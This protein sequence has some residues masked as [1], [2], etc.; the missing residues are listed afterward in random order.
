MEGRSCAVE[1]V[2][3]ERCE[4]DEEGFESELS[5]V[6]TG[7][8]RAGRVRRARDLLGASV[9]ASSC[10]GVVLGDCSRD[11]TELGKAS[12]SGADSLRGVGPDAGSGPSVVLLGL[13]D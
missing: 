4:V 1:V 12:K 6:A 11:A 9:L 10:A 3:R 2:E 7:G 5:K 13:L 8:G